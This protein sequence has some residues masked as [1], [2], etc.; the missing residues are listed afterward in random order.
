MI[1]RIDEAAAIVEFGSKFLRFI[2]KKHWDL[3]FLLFL[4]LSY[5]IILF[6]NYYH[7]SINQIHIY[8][9]CPKSADITFT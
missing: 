5:L 3:S 6:F 9:P 8:T 4:H 1:R 7:W 2:F